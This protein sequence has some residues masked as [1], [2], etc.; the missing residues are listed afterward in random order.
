LRRRLHPAKLAKIDLMVEYSK[1]FGEN[2][3]HLN[4]FASCPVCGVTGGHTLD[5]ARWLPAKWNSSKQ[6]Y[7]P[8]EPSSRPRRPRRT[9]AWLGCVRD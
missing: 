7:C 1:V 2:L 8:V 4:A 5:N 9:N 3:E 6:N